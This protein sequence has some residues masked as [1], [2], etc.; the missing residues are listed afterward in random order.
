MQVVSLPRRSTVDR[1]VQTAVRAAIV[2]IAA[3]L[4]SSAHAQ[5]FTTLH[6]FTGG[7]GGSNPANLIHAWQH[8]R[9]RRVQ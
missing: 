3:I 5:T 4:S 6:T 8:H 7:T 2:A 9:R 1:I